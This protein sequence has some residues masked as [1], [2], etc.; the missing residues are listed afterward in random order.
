MRC[1]CVR[2]S[3]EIHCSGIAA[4]SQAGTIFVTTHDSIAVGLLDHIWDSRSCSGIHEQLSQISFSC[5]ELGGW[6]KGFGF[7]IYG[8]QVVVWHIRERC[9]VGMEGCFLAS[10]SAVRLK[11]KPTTKS[12][13]VTGRLLGLGRSATGL[14]FISPPTFEQYEPSVA[15]HCSVLAP[16]SSFSPRSNIGSSLFLHWKKQGLCLRLGHP[17]QTPP[18]NGW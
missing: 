16:S 10:C 1:Q 6:D 12:Q 9:G 3:I 15:H 11:N 2:V 17:T 7:G 4:L 8:L 13:L 5:L 14:S 18:T